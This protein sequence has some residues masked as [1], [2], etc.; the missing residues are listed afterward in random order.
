VAKK[1]ASV[2][3]SQDMAAQVCG[4]IPAVKQRR[5]CILFDLRVSNRHMKPND[6]SKPDGDLE[7]PPLIPYYF[8]N[9]IQRESGEFHVAPLGILL[10]GLNLPINYLTGAPSRKLMGRLIAMGRS[11]L[12]QSELA[13]ISSHSFNY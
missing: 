12:N 13:T 7:N 11:K 5:E 10:G 3:F 9:Q 2:E 1:T 8:G 6:P 4:L